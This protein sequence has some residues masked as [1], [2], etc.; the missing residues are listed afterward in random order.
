MP[1]GMMLTTALLPGCQRRSA[2][3]SPAR[4][5]PSKKVASTTISVS[6]I[7]AMYQRRAVLPI[8]ARY[9][10]DGFGADHF[11]L[12]QSKLTVFDHH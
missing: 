10:G 5:S 12:V 6:V 9:L 4:T 11:K 8:S 1:V 7:C 3:S 2:G